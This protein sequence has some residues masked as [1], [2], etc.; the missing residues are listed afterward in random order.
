VKRVSEAD[1][2]NLIKGVMGEDDDEPIS[3]KDVMRE[4]RE[5]FKKH[6]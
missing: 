4:A 6:I 5:V 2:E 3:T 1:Y